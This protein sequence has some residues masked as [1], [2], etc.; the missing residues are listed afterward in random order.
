LRS[1]QLIPALL[2]GAERPRPSKWC[3]RGPQPMCAATQPRR[4]RRSRLVMHDH[5]LLARCLVPLRSS[6]LQSQVSPPLCRLMLAA[7]WTRSL[8]TRPR[9]LAAQV[10]TASSVPGPPPTLA[11]LQP[12]PRRPLPSRTLF[13]LPG[14]PQL[15]PARSSALQSP[16][17]AHPAPLTRVT[18]PL[19]PR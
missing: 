13:L 18:A 8:R 12:R 16:R 6:V 4:H 10:T 3:A 7:L 17:L 19:S 5:P 2:L 11:A 9:A 1:P 14:P 15:R